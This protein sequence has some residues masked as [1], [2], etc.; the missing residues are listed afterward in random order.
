MSRESTPLHE[1][2]LMAWLRAKGITR[3]TS[4]Q[5]MRGMR[6]HQVPEPSKTLWELEKKGLLTKVLVFDDDLGFAMSEY[7]VPAED[8]SL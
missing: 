1:K 8:D 7:K 5:A 6:E 2:R 3:I 4:E